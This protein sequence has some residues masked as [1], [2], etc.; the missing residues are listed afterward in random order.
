[1]K[2]VLFLFI[3]NLFLSKNY[4]LDDRNFD[5]MIKNYPNTTWVILFH[6]ENCTQ[7]PE[8]FKIFEKI[9]DK[10]KELIHLKFSQIN[11]LINLYSCI[12]FNITYLPSILLLEN[13]YYYQDGNYLTDN[14]FLSFINEDK[15]L[16][17]GKSIPPAL[18]YIHIFFQSMSEIIGIFNKEIQ[19][20]ILRVLGFKFQWENYHS[21]L[22]I[23]SLIITISA[24]EFF[25][26]LCC[27]KRKHRK[28]KIEEDSYY[29]ENISEKNN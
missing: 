14:S 1:M 9:K 28:I 6:N 22:M 12:R 27:I 18:G 13:D 2:I 3:L 15:D 29:S 16:I 25:I 20:L 8:T 11:C 10:T 19:R 24:F 17:Q 26:L 7:C 23:L 4:S 21:I 5:N